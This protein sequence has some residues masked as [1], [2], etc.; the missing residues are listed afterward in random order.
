MHGRSR[1]RTSVTDILLQMPPH[2]G[3][4]R[5]KPRR[6]SA[7]A[8]PGLPPVLPSQAAAAAGPELEVTDWQDELGSL[9]LWLAKNGTGTR[10]LEEQEEPPDPLEEQDVLAGVQ[11]NNRT[12]ECLQEW[13]SL[14]TASQECPKIIKTGLYI[15][16]ERADKHSYEES[17]NRSFTSDVAF[18]VKA[19]EELLVTG[20][21]EV[22][23][24]AD[25]R[26]INPL[27][28]AIN[29]RGKK[30]L[31]LDLSRYVNIFTKTKK[32]SLEAVNTFARTVRRGDFM[33][34]F[35]LSSG[36]M[37]GPPTQAG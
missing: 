13:V 11:I 23:S 25:L 37:I 35:D 27:S 3:R 24:K 18:G 17:N 34:I 28:I 14:G 29:S 9:K 19:I 8:I 31:C 1:S 30:R 21:V 20:A 22:C 32:C 2:T 5:V 15:N 12:K 6:H 4:R 33:V 16:I 10:F 36:T 7:P 26:A